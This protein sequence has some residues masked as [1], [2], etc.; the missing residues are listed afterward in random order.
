MS[1]IVLKMDGV[2]VKQRGE[3]SYPLAVARWRQLG[4]KSVA[5]TV[6]LKLNLTEKDKKI[7]V[8]EFNYIHDHKSQHTQFHNLKVMKP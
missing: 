8:R 6:P 2:H 4:R 1:Y 3:L 7:S 5:S